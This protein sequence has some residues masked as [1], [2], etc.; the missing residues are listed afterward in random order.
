YTVAASA[1]GSASVAVQLHD[2]GGTANG[3]IDTSSPQTF[4]VAVSK[5]NTTTSINPSSAS[6][7]LGASLTLTA[8]VSVVAPG[9]GTPTAGV[10]FMDGATALS[11][12]VAL[13]ANGVATFSTSSLAAG[14][15]AVTAVYGGGA[16]FNGST[17]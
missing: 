10:T 5:A 14:T 9:A 2:N 16:S 8:T 12:S 13:N 15:H 17:S 7:R 1:N 6:F 11:G 3:G 4:T